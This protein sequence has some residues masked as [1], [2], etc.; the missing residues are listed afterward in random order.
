MAKEVELIA[1]TGVGTPEKAGVATKGAVG[2]GAVEGEVK[3]DDNQPSELGLS[4][5]GRGTGWRSSCQSSG[6]NSSVS[7][8]SLIS[9]VSLFVYL[10]LM[11]SDS[12]G[13]AKEVELIATT[14]VGTPEKAGVV[15]KG[16]AGAGAVEGEA[17]LDDSQP[18]ELGLSSAG[19][20]TG[21]G[22]SCQS[23]GS[24]SSVS[25]T[26]LVSSVL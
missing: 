5:T 21:W 19:G 3:L 15:T 17:K 25:S 2:A 9:S 14:G 8:T 6:S 10:P 24:N 12:P 1:T 23:S 4:S 26:S 22:F 18:S 11:I 13:M 7:S 16:A 20:E